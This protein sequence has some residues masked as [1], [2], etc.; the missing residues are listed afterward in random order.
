MQR[1]GNPLFIINLFL[2]DIKKFIIYILDKIWVDWC[3]IL[4]S[5]K[6]KIIEHYKIIG[7]DILHSHCTHLGRTYN[8]RSQRITNV[9]QINRRCQ[10]WSISSLH[11]LPQQRGFL[12]RSTMRMRRHTWLVYSSMHGKTSCISII[13]CK[14]CVM[15][16]FC[17]MWC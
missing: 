13:I 14:N 15:H 7:A 2:N 4:Y 1:R 10:F 3:G 17:T 16:E 5:L 12:F 8:D 6:Y 11:N 9:I